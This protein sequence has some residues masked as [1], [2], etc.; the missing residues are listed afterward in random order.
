MIFHSK[1]LYPIFLLILFLCQSPLPAQSSIDAE[2][3]KEHVRILSDESMEGRGIGTEGLNLAREYLIG[4]FESIGLEP[5]DEKGFGQGYRVRLNQIWVDGKNIIGILPGKDETL[6]REAIVIFA[7]YDHSGYR[8]TNGEK[9]VYPGADMNASG[10]AALLELAAYFKQ[11]ENRPDRTLVFAA[12]DTRK[13]DSHGGTQFIQQKN[14]LDY[15]LKFGLGLNSLGHYTSDRGLNLL[16]LSSLAD[17]VETAEKVADSHSI[18]IANTGYGPAHDTELL[19]FIR[20]GIPAALADA[21]PH[22]SHFGVEDTYDK[23]QYDDMKTTVEFLA[24]WIQELGDGGRSL[25]PS[26]SFEPSDFSTGWAPPAPEPA[27]FKYGII[28]HGGSGYQRF[29]DEYFRSNGR[30]NF[31]AGFKAQFHFSRSLSLQPELLFDLNGGR[32]EGGD[33]RRTSI[34][35]PLNLQWDLSSKENSDRAFIFA[36]GYYRYHLGGKVDGSSIDYEL[37]FR[38]EEYGF[39]FGFGVEE[40]DF[41]ELSLTM[42]R[43]V[44]DVLRSPSTSFR[45]VNKLVTLGIRL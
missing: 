20:S 34:T 17:G 38:K 22:S 24:E 5:Y 40:L 36:G 11:T 2:K 44:N 3:L 30:F 45:D 35:A 9:R 25:Q 12:F 37:D 16:F 4:Q 33:Y 13:Y 26:D 18:D 6:N 31:A 10:V 41:F 19:D 1:L 27:I 14:Q 8:M 15:D 43:A 39:S 7:N 42:R 29:S 23:L 28:I 21:G 32:Y